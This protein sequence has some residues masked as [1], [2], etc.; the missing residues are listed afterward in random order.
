MQAVGGAHCDKLVD[1]VAMHKRMKQRG[2]TNECAQ[3]PQYQLSPHPNHK[4]N[5]FA[6]QSRDI[7]SV[8]WDDD[9]AAVY[10]SHSVA[11]KCSSK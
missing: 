9:F 4:C 7:L 3:Y 5:T 6:T 8:S 2:I 10:L 11:L 1:A